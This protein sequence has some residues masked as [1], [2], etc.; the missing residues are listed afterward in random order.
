MMYV[1]IQVDAVECL[2]HPNPNQHFAINLYLVHMN[3]T[4]N[5]RGTE[6]ESRHMETNEPTESHRHVY[7][8]NP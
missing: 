6:A 8:P 2:T 5:S 7:F 4:T 1:Y 3:Q